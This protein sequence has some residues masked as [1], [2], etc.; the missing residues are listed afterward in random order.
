MAAMT[1]EVRTKGQITKG[2]GRKKSKN[3]V[4]WGKTRHRAG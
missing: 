1:Q 3:K 2:Q 4:I